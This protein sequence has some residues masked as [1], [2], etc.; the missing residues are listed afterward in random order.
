MKRCAELYETAHNSAGFTEIWSTG[1]T[2][3]M[4]NLTDGQKPLKPQQCV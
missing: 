1:F 3:V 2:R 4:G